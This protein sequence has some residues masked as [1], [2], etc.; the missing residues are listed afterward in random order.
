MKIYVLKGLT[1]KMFMKIC[2]YYKNVQACQS[3]IQKANVASKGQT[4]MTITSH[5]MQYTENKI[6]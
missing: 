5:E 4:E 3:A 1:I 6:N 2:P